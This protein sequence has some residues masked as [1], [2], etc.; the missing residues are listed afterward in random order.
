MYEYNTLQT[1]GWDRRES[2]DD[3]G[4]GIINFRLTEHSKTIIGEQ[5]K[6]WLTTVSVKHHLQR[7]MR[8]NDYRQN[9][10][11]CSDLDWEV[12]FHTSTRLIRYSE[13]RLC[14]HRTQGFTRTI[15]PHHYLQS[16]FTHNA[17]IPR[18]QHFSARNAT[19][20]A[21]ETPNQSHR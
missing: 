18:L 10:E 5:R 4:G 7:S 12:V 13:H 2:K 3:E 17:I 9:L 20:T 14:L 19:P 1:A 8:K 15:K 16:K 21:A 6:L 11:A